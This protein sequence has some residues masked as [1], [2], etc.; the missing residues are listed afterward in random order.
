MNGD[1]DEIHGGWNTP[2]DESSDAEPVEVTGEFTIDYTPPAW[3]TQNASGDASGGAGAHLAPPPPPQ[4][5]PLSVPGLP[6]GGGFPPTWSPQAAP[7]AERPA[8]PEP[9]SSEPAPSASSSAPGPVAPAVPGAD[10]PDSTDSAEGARAERQE[11]TPAG[12]GQAAPF[13]GGDVESGATMRFSPAALKREIEERE[14]ARTDPAAPARPVG[15][16]ATDAPESG[17]AP[18]DATAAA[19]DR[20]DTPPGAAAPAAADHPG[21][22]ARVRARGMTRGRRRTTLT[23][24]PRTRRLPAPRRRPATRR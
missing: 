21:S 3:Y 19:T 23:P 22:G 1:R 7:E 2:V 6:A 5:A 9:G 20:A 4:G 13:G 15:D 17:A 24:P 8:A 16:G 12:Q 18:A 10:G 14:A 11:E